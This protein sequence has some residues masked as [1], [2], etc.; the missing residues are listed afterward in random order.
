MFQDDSTQA[1]LLVDASNAFNSLNRSTALQNICRLCPSLATILI[2]TYRHPIDL[3]FHDIVLHS[4]EGTT[5]G[6]PLAMTMYAIAT[7]PLIKSLRTTQKEVSQTWYADDA[8]TSGKIDQL[9]SWR[10]HL[11]IE[12]PKFGYLPMLSK[13]G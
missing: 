12:G 10:E 2:N 13:L 4:A 5:Q 8:C 9:Y 3:H 11:S 6:D 7:I 1:F